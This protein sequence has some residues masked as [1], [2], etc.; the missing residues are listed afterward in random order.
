MRNVT[1]FC[2]ASK[3]LKHDVFCLFSSICDFED[4]IVE[5]LLQTMEPQRNL[6]NQEAWGPGEVCGL[7]GSI[8]QPI[9]PKACNCFSLCLVTSRLPFFIDS[10]SAI[11]E[12]LK[13]V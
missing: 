7:L 1:T 11:T 4:E 6:E 8:F 13:Q 2:L 10:F 5:V 9:Q 12:L 3:R